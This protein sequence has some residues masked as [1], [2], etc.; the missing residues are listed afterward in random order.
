[1][2]KKIDECRNNPEN[3]FRTKVGE[4]IPS[5]STISPFKN[6]ENKHD[7]YRCRDCMK[8]VCESLREYAM[9]II[10]FKNKKGIH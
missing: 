5:V 7:L 1:M 9:E 8:N 3:S 4:H 10:I 6:I 2:I